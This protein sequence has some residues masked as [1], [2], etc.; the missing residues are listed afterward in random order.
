MKKVWKKLLAAAGMTAA[1]VSTSGC[2]VS[3]QF[4]R[5]KRQLPQKLSSSDEK[6]WAAEP[7]WVSSGEAG[8]LTK[9]SK[10]SQAFESEFEPES[11]KESESEQETA[12]MTEK[13]SES[14]T[15]ST[16]ADSFVIPLPPQVG[17]F[18]LKEQDKLGRSKINE[19]IIMEES[20]D[21]RNGRNNDDDDGM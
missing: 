3:I 19:K 16:T 10:E 5:S 9:E 17:R 15:E 2:M 6:T 11:E 1:L 18:V 21:Y 4:D 8:V 13:E 12:E 20:G 14:L 7:V